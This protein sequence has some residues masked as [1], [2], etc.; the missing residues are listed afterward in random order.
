MTH[1][2]F[3]RLE[4]YKVV[5][6]IAIEDKDHALK[7]ADALIQGGLPIAEITFRTEAAADVI[8]TLKTER[9]EILVGAGTI[10]TAEQLTKAID[11]GAA[12]GVAPG[13][14]P[15]IVEQAIDNQFPFAPG[16][17]TPSDVEAAL[18]LGLKVLKFFPAEAA[19]GISFLKSM[20]G[21]YKHTGVRF[22]PT[23]GVNQNNLTE[24]LAV[25]TVL[26]AGGTWVAKKEMLRRQQWSLVTE[27]CQKINQ[28][29]KG[30]P[31]T[32]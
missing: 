25:D 24:Y 14:N 13:V 27:N 30:I 28:I 17:M 9:P 21:P 12:F 11:C 16:V 22:I 10:L 6:V 1:S 2:V 29:L 20:S 31:C 19:G 32:G 15:N 5:P 4:Q 23:G 8:K 7:L 3:K 18:A 26:A